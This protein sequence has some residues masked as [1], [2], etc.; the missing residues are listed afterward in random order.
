MDHHGYR[1][2]GSSGKSRSCSGRVQGKVTTEETGAVPGEKEVKS[3][4]P[5]VAPQISL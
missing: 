4:R 5:S 2:R 1:A 3:D